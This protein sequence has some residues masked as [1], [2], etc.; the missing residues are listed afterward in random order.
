MVV[1]QPIESQKVAA[2]S[3]TCDLQTG[4]VALAQQ[5]AMD[6]GFKEVFGVIG[7]AKLLS[8]SVLAVITGAEQASFASPFAEQLLVRAGRPASLSGSLEGGSV[9]DK[10]Q[11]T[12]IA[13][14]AASRARHACAAGCYA[15]WLACVSRDRDRA[16]RQE[17]A[18]TYG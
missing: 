1:L 8:G 11:T 9:H 13:G 15:P 2:Q 17:Q 16:G 3:L 4:N 5:D 12:A 14:F 6:K 7:L 18:D 10:Q